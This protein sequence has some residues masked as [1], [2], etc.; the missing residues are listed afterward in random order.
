MSNFLERVKELIRAGDVMISEH[1]YDEI[2]DN[3]LSPGCGALGCDLYTEV[4]MMTQRKKL[5]Y[6]HEGQYVAEVEVE[7]VEDGTGWS[8]YIG[9]EDALKLD[10]V[11]DALRNGKLAEAAKYGKIF[12]LRPVSPPMPA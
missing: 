11:R 5:K 10:D 8:P 9:V 2:I 6:V 1:G 3:S 4:V 12:E 7:L